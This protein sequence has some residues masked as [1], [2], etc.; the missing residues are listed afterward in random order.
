MT[1]V[2]ALTGGIN[3][4][5]N[6]YKAVSSGEDVLAVTVDIQYY[7]GLDPIIPGINPERRRPIIIGNTTNYTIIDPRSN[8]EIINSGISFYYKKD[9]LTKS[10]NIVNWINTNVKPI[11]HVVLTLDNYIPKYSAI[12]QLETIN[13]GLSLPNTT[14][15]IL[16]FGFESMDKNSI[17]IKNA[18]SKINTA[19]NVS[20][21]S[22]SNESTIDAINKLPFQLLELCDS[23]IWSSSIIKAKDAGIS[24]SDILT[25]INNI[26]GIGLNPIPHYK[27][28][29][30]IEYV[31]IENFNII[32]PF[33][34]TRSHTH[35]KSMFI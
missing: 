4:T 22:T 29:D 1:T 8:T 9:N 31:D 28:S 12:S 23:N 33:P 19:N 7:G 17:A 14:Q 27:E 21:L 2:V 5:Y 16:G 30:G 6:L 13:Y 25:T 11:Q 35:L 26:N 32:F 3:E 18:V 15:I 10:N 20:Y 24:N 34:I